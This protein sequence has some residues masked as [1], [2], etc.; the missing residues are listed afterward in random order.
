MHPARSQKGSAMA[1]LN[2]RA[3]V[4]LRLQHRATRPVVTHNPHEKGLEP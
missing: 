3:D 4:V 2:V 1:A